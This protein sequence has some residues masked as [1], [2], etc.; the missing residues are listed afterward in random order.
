[1]V[2][3]AISDAR[4]EAVDAYRKHGISEGRAGQI[5]RFTDSGENAITY[6]ISLTALNT[7]AEAVFSL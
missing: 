4:L 5:F 2:G 7:D 6:N 1:M 3:A